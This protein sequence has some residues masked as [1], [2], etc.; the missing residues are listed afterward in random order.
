MNTTSQPLIKLTAVLALCLSALSWS[1]VMGIGFLLAMLD[2]A[3]TVEP[4]EQPRRRYW[5][6]EL[7]AVLKQLFSTRVW[8]FYLV[9]VG[10]VVI[11]DT[12]QQDSRDK[13]ATGAGLASRW[14]WSEEHKPAQS[15]LCACGKPLGHEKT[16]SLPPRPALSA[17]PSALETAKRVDA[18]K[19]R[20]MS[21]DGRSGTRSVDSSAVNLPGIGPNPPPLPP[22][23]TP[24]PNAKLPVGVKT[25]EDRAQG[26]K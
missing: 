12:R 14:A 19:Q 15:G 4:V 6:P 10:V 23:M 2:A 22:G 18:L 24:N 1:G 5:L 11:G 16:V 21:S 26:A 7:L 13:T 9:L 17:P 25:Q 20:T 8:P 3:Q